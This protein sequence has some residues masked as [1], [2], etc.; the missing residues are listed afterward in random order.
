[1]GQKPTFGFGNT[2][3]DA[4]AYENGAIPN[5]YFFKFT[6]MA[7]GGRRIDAYTDV[8]GEFGSLSPACP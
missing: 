1:M 8:L 4:Q 5:R 7:F 2:D 3:T 6:D